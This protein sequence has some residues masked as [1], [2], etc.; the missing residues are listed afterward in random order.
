MHYRQLLSLLEKADLS[1]EQ[2]AA[3]LGVSNMTLRRWRSKPERAVLP[4]L[5]R[6]AFEPT[7]QR[8]VGEGRLHPEDP[9]VAAALAPT[10]DSFQSTLAR[11]GIT[12]DVLENADRHQ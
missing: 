2:A 11:L 12:H 6:H 9:D 7:V 3:D 5:Y 1:P 8:L 10:G 4:E